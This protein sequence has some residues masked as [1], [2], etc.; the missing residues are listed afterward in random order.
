MAIKLTIIPKKLPLIQFPFIG[1]LPSQS[2]A[3]IVGW[4]IKSI[5]KLPKDVIIINPKKK[6]KIN[7][8]KNDFCPTKTS[9][10][11]IDNNAIK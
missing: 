2:K 3:E 11:A 4:N 8:V 5:I 1:K 9:S 10:K 6:I 7:F